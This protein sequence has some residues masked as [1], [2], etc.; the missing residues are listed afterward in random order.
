F[1]LR[2]QSAPD[3]RTTNNCVGTR[4]GQIREQQS[5]IREDGTLARF[6]RNEGV[7][8]MVT[9]ERETVIGSPDLDTVTTSHVERAFPTV[10]QE[11][12]RF[13]RRGLGTAKTWKRTS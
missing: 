4:T 3:N 2:R 13:Q 10:R 6:G 12:K 8:K 9:A 5:G 7:R 11:L 1:L